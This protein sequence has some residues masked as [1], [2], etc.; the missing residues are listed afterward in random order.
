MKWYAPVKILTPIV[1]VLLLATCASA[2][3]TD[4]RSMYPDGS[5]PEGAWKPYKLSKE[6]IDAAP[7]STKK[8]ALDVAIW[9]ETGRNKDASNCFRTGDPFRCL[10]NAAADGKAARIDVES[11]GIDSM[12][13]WGVAVVPDH[14]M[15]IFSDDSS[16]CGGITP[17]ACGYSLGYFKCEK[18]ADISAHRHSAQRTLCAQPNFGLDKQ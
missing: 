14:T 8:D 17:A 7:A 2:W 5:A 3:L 6:T 13:G 16:P 12:G 11:F 4:G 18:L 10:L 1:M 15:T 9:N